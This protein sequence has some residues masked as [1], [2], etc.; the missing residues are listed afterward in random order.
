M[1]IL[2]NIQTSIACDQSSIA[3]VLLKLSLLATKLGSEKLESW[4][5]FESEGYPDSVELP[6]YRKIPLAF[7]ANFAGPFGAQI[8]N[9][10]VPGYLVEK[11]GGSQ[12]NK[13]N[14]RE[15][16]SSLENL[17]ARSS[18]NISVDSS[19][20]ILL[21]QGKIYPGYSC[22]SVTGNFS[23]SALVGIQ[24]LIRHRI[25]KFTLQLEKSIPLANSITFSDDMK[26]DLS[27]HNKKVTQIFNQTF[28]GDHTIISS[29]E[30]S[31]INSSVIK[32]DKSS[33]CTYLICNRLPEKDANN[34][35]DIISS[36][37]P[38][39]SDN[40]FGIKMKKWIKEKLKEKSEIWKMTYSTAL[41]IIKKAVSAYYGL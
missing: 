29:G 41:E 14:F 36:E 9:A 20:L 33:L 19:N 11:F 32:G 10:P 21:L 6:N 4:I 3:S 25:L 18:S 39:N 1:S 7:I 12:W 22:I 26:K 28:Y 37:K 13:C 31:T 8:N 15:S 23:V 2:H 30:N 38:I 5:E 24:N 34:L 27:D 17:I 40:P 35:A 16:I